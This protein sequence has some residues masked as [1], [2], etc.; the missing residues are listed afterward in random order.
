MSPVLLRA[1]AW[2]A[3]LGLSAVAGATGA[4]AV[5]LRGGSAQLVLQLSLVMVGAAA[6]CVLDEPA[7][8]VV[9]ACPVPRLTQVALRAFASLVPVGVGVAVVTAYWSRGVVERILLLE[10]A[11]CWVLGFALAVLARARLDEPT[12]VVAPGLALVLLS[13]LLVNPIG[14]QLVLFP[15]DDQL[16]RGVRTWWL[17]VV[18]CSVAVVAAVRERRWRVR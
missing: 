17:V 18:G 9:G 4:L 11:G 7:A 1:V 15:D 8:A 14:R 13:V 3:L 5:L 6:A 16:A 12:E 10:L 2:R